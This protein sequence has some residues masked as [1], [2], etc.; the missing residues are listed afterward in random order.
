MAGDGIGVVVT[1]FE[2]ERG[3]R[4]VGGDVCVTVTDVGVGAAVNIVDDVVDVACTV[5]VINGVGGGAIVSAKLGV[6]VVE[7]THDSERLEGHVVPPQVGYCD[8][9]T[10]IERNP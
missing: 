9:I 7:Q 4:P 3:G 2:I 8:T 6:I 1:K 10:V 5:V